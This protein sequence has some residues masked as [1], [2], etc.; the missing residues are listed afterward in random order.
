MTMKLSWTIAAAA[1][2]AA[3]AA[4]ASAQYANAYVTTPAYMRTGPDT[5]YPPVLIVPANAPVTVYG[6]ING[7]HWCDVSWGAN[8][9]WIAGPYL[10]AMWQNRPTPFY[11]AAPYYHVPIVTFY[12]GNYWGRWDYG[13]RRWR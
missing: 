9:G 13:H 8:R 1:L 4:P 12:F 11:V 3:S 7:W 2:F 5:M 6:C 10:A